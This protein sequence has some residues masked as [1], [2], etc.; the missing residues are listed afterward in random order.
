MAFTDQTIKK[1]DGVAT[2]VYK[3]LIP[4]A[5]DGSSALYRLAPPAGTKSVA[6]LAQLKLVAKAN[7]PQT[8]R[9]V[10]ATY[11]MPQTEASATGGVP[12]VVGNVPGRFEITLP[13]A[14][15]LDVQ[16]EAVDQF[17]NLLAT[18]EVRLSIKAAI[19]PR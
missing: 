5:G 18:P 17:L 6:E 16:A 19:A 8:A 14:V 2:V 1:A 4:S 10:V 13:N 9:R 3:A 12:T 7:G 15:S 11:S